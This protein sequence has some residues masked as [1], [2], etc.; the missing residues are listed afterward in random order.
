MFELSPRDVS[1]KP[2][3]PASISRKSCFDPREIEIEIEI[4]LDTSNK[5]SKLYT[6]IYIKK[7]ESKDAAKLT[8]R[9]TINN[10]TTFN[11]DETIRRVIRNYA[12][13]PDTTINYRC[14]IF[15][16]NG[17]NVYCRSIHSGIATYK[18]SGALPLPGQCY[19]S[20]RFSNANRPPYNHC[21][22]APTRNRR[23]HVRVSRVPRQRETPFRL[24]DRRYIPHSRRRGRRRVEKGMTHFQQGEKGKVLGY[25]GSHPLDSGNREEKQENDVVRW[26][27]TRSNEIDEETFGIR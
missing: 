19:F 21:P 2:N 6:Y 22:G 3:F 15:T 25:A 17:A 24:S 18:R 12:N 20:K 8:I 5:C 9:M 26:R 1:N 23:N 14:T 7:K 16:G 4:A 10:L 11:S 27:R 13:C